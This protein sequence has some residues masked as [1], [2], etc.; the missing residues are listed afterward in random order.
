MVEGRYLE[1]RDRRRGQ[2]ERK[3]CR[4]AGLG[5][6]GRRSR[7]GTLRQFDGGGRK[8]EREG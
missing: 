6:R 1:E 4:E 8:E 5:R 7:K 3:D 2:R